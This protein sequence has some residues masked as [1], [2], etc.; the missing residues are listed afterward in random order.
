MDN[1]VNLVSPSS[2][3]ES[4]FICGKVTLSVHSN[5]LNHS[6]PPPQFKVKLFDLI[7]IVQGK[8]NRLVLEQKYEILTP[9]IN[10]LW[11]IL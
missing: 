6:P 7:I 2:A 10:Q 3:A 5:L 11:E 4:R 1:K 9:G 8:K